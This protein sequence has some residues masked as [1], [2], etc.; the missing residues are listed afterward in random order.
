VAL[1]RSVLR[2]ELFAT[3]TFDR[4][5][6]IWANWSTME[7]ELAASQLVPAAECE[8]ICHGEERLWAELRF[9]LKP[10]TRS[11]ITWADAA[12]KECQPSEDVDRI[13]KVC[14]QKLLSEGSS[15]EFRNAIPVFTHFARWLCSKERVVPALTLLRTTIARA[16]K[17][18]CLQLEALADCSCEISLEQ[19]AAISP[20]VLSVAS[21][22][23][24]AEV[25]ASSPEEGH[26]W[27]TLWSLRGKLKERDVVHWSTFVAQRGQR[28]HSR[29]LLCS[30]M[31][32]GCVPAATVLELVPKIDAS[33]QLSSEVMRGLHERACFESAES[34]P[35]LARFE[36]AHGC[37]RAALVA[38][39]RYVDADPA[40]VD[41]F[42]SLVQ[43][44]LRLQ[45][46]D[47]LRTLAASATKG[48][49]AHII[50]RRAILLVQG[51]QTLGERSSSRAVFKQASTL[52]DPRSDP[53]G[54]WPLWKNFEV[55][56]GTQETFE[57]MTRAE[58]SVAEKYSGVEVQL[59]TSGPKAFQRRR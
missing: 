53:Y 56:F 38:L 24:Q 40:Q 19:G 36:E 6:F 30:A 29:R 7:L 4:F 8:K 5:H 12:E 18:G 59:D 21:P 31:L 33:P 43:A 16:K 48:A 3:R 17:S 2:R 44:T 58:R 10:S 37:A 28:P 39:Q 35:A 1:A 22:T 11:A 52:V 32:R 13:F 34:L 25:A 45:G 20:E 42:G 27:D 50:V 51:L 41:R 57:D 9:T 23:M 26:L 54:F 47:A 55:E 14:I 15:T 49:T 46:A